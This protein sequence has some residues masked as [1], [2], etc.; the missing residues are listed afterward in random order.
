MSEVEVLDVPAPEVIAVDPVDP[1][2]QQDPPAPEPAPEPELSYSYQPTDEAGRPMGGA[3]VL[4]YRTQDELIQKMQEQNTLLIRKLR[5]ET[6]KNR[7]GITDQEVIPEESPRFQE[8]MDFS[9]RS[10][11]PDER[12]KLSRD[13]LDPEQF[14]EATDMLFEAKMG[15]KPEDLRKEMKAQQEAILTLQAKQETDAFLQANPNYFKC[16]ENFEAITGWMMKRKLQPVKDNFQMAYDELTKASVLVES[17]APVPAPVRVEVRPE[18][19]PTPAPAPVSR[20]PSGL[21]RNQAADTGTAP[22]LGDDIVY[23][24]AQR[25]APAKV[26]R[27]MQAVNAM[28]SDEFKR[29]INHEPGF[30]KKVEKL[31]QALTAQRARQRTVFE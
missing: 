24:L 8:P 25:G 6:R 2:D 19:E 3:Q 17:P 5:Q 18:P 20:I 23:E 15:A 9:A 28:P 13:L 11:T 4:K 21:T 10:L 22:R 27:G 16:Q 31:E 26:L 7:L 30:A 14:D 12:V 29:R 1:I